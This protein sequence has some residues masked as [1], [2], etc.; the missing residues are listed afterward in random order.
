MILENG[1]LSL[2][3]I[4]CLGMEFEMDITPRMRQI[5]NVLL[6]E[7]NAISVKYL[8]EQIGVSKRTAQRELEYISGS[9]KGYDLVFWSKTGVGIRLDGSPEEKRR[10]ME[11]ISEGDSYDT[12][13]R[14]ERRKRL[15]LEILREKE[16]RKLFYYS[17]R[18]GVSETTVSA[19]LESIEGWLLQ[20]GLRV[21]RK[22]GSGISV[23]GSEEDYRRAIRAFINEN[24]DTKMLK[25][26]YETTDSAKEHRTALE[27]SEI[28]Q[29][30]NDDILRR[31]MDCITGM[32]HTRVMTLTESAYTGIVIHIAIA[33]NRILKN[34]TIDSKEE[35]QQQ[36]PRDEDFH[37]AEEIV[38]ELEEE[39][40]IE[41]PEVE[42][43]YIC[44]H[45]KGAKHEKIVWDGEDVLPAGSRELQQ[46]VNEMVDV[47]DPAQAYL[48][49]QDD[50]FIQGLLA[51][52]RPTM[53][54]L[55]HGMQIQNP[56]LDEI[57]ESY[58]EIY[59][60]CL[61]VAKVL[62]EKTGCLVPEEETGFLTVHFGAAVVR[63]EGRREQIRKVY[64]GVVC[65]SGIGISR[66]MTSKLEKT[67]KERME[68]T[69]YGKNDITPY[70][71]SKTDFFITSIL[72]EIQ[73]IP[74]I[75][76]NPLLSDEDME[77]IR[78][79]TCQYE[80]MPEKQREKNEFT[81]Q[82]E[83]INLI[84]AKISQVIKY[85]EFF[86]VDNRISFEELLVA[87]G[88][89]MSPY[90]D[91][92]EMIREDLARR[93]RISSQ[94]FA[95]FGF[96]LL[97]ARTKGVVRPSFAVCMTKDLKCFEDPYMKGIDI[98]FV[99]LV[100]AD[101]HVKVDNDIMGYISSMLI[102]EYDFMDTVRM[103][104]KEK[105]RALLSKYLKK[106]FN[107][108]LTGFGAI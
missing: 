46:I 34:E 5:L 105:I 78:K 60:K 91:R 51:H 4:I 100:P 20:Y 6:K 10:L 12:G 33:V 80:R 94:V 68:L 19:D 31:V 85:M 43:A 45:I 89:K 22:P 108:Y 83:Q 8:A 103:G 101:G 1:F 29:I 32:N 39:F 57:K 58:A 28:G 3:L 95:E 26:I 59:G 48:L 73:E 93:E 2:A 47:F 9:L 52:L 84:A 65:S 88:E 27:K 56:V 67:F 37:L 106:Y 66:L 61:R 71:I 7:E 54:R 69:A 102:E 63:L 92:S 64:V 15:I 98:V 74:V 86:K 36:I 107:K 90:S 87:V 42:T 75:Y 25:E 18:F 79:M 24:I 70:V 41:I 72:L 81:E 62:E 76:V 77:N 11:E 82:L 17:D 96:A 30:L 104:D 21:I 38:R 50:E 49:K 97:H 35:W 23:E 16:L 53:I 14:E 13:N 44:L 40:E 55:T 99:M